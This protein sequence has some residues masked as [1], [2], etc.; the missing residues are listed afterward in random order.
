[1]L[2]WNYVVNAKSGFFR[3]VSFRDVGSRIFTVLDP[4]FSALCAGRWYVSMFEEMMRCN[5]CQCEINF[6][7]TSEVIVEQIIELLSLEWT[8]VC[9]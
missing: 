8:I 1:M 5:S 2:R 9:D 6:C 3:R 7:S 4:E